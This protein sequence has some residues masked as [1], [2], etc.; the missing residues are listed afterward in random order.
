ML[1]SNKG[2]HVAESPLH[3]AAKLERL[4]PQRKS[5]ESSSLPAPA[6][7]GASRSREIRQLSANLPQNRGTSRRTGAAEA[8][9][10]AAHSQSAKELRRPRSYCQ[11]AALAST[12]IHA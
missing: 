12:S 8:M 6:K 1:R 9:W 10:V 2:E 4:R 3:A 11:A 7:P 5:A